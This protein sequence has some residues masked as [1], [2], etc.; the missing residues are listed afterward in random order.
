MQPRSMLE[1]FIK[2][3]VDNTVPSC[4]DNTVE[5]EFYYEQH[6]AGCSRNIVKW[7]TFSLKLFQFME[8]DQFTDNFFEEYKKIISDTR[9]L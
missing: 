2:W 6:F 1:R 4:I 7:K 9:A 3:V 5:L 8:H